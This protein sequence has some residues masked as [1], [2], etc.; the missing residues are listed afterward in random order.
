MVR[1]AGGV[2]SL[3]YIIQRIETGDEISVACLS[4]RGNIV[5]RKIMQAHRNGKKSVCRV[6]LDNGMELICTEDHRV[7]TSNRGWIQVQY[8]LPEDEIITTDDME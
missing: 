5:Y 3:S 1:T 6:K 4:E 2:F 8:L 7:L